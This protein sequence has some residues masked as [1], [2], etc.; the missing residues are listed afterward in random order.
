[1][2]E[3]ITR[4]GD[5]NAHFLKSNVSFCAHKKN[6]FKSLSISEYNT[7]GLSHMLN[8]NSTRTHME[9]NFKSNDIGEGRVVDNTHYKKVVRYLRYTCN[10]RPYICHG[11]GMVRTFKHIINIYT[12]VGS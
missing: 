2:H 1:M 9:A 10:S 3:W 8:F 12:Y 7:S 4:E 11:L 5:Y 6:Y